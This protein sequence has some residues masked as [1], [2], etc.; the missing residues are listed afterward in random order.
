MVQALK[1]SEQ[2]TRCLVGSRDGR[3]EWGRRQWEQ[4]RVVR[5]DHHGSPAQGDQDKSK[6]LFPRT[7]GCSEQS[8]KFTPSPLVRDLEGFVDGVFRGCQQPKG[9]CPSSLGHTAEHLLQKP[10]FQEVS[11]PAVLP[12]WLDI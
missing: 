4:E 2:R 12:Q 8:P 7:T 9:P 10:S 3:S 6:T 11:W 5:W 1:D